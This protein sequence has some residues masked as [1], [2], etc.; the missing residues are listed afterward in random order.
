MCDSD[1]FCILAATP[2]AW[3]FL[4]WRAADPATGRPRLLP[5]EFFDPLPVARH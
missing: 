2:E 4:G 1:D 5:A 3:R